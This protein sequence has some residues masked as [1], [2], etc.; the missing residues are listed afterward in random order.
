MPKSFPKA[1]QDILNTRGPVLDAGIVSSSSAGALT[2]ASK[3]WPDGLFDGCL[4]MLWGGAFNFAWAYVDRSISNALTLLGTTIAA[5]V[6]SYYAV[7]PPPAFKAGRF[8]PLDDD[9]DTQATRTSTGFRNGGARG[10]LL[11]VVIANFTDGGASPT[12]TPSIQAQFPAATTAVA[13]FRTIWQA[14]AALAANGAIL[15]ELYPGVASGGGEQYTEQASIVL[16]FGLCRVVLTVA[17]GDG[18]NHADT[19][20]RAIFLP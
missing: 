17:N 16:P 10:L 7:F 11:E 15:Y 14:S 20:V 4:V 5:E 19:L 2:D 1:F 9:A 3:A 12:V 18:D 13:T 6:G 8:V